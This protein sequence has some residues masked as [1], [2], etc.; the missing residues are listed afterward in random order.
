MA[1]TDLVYKV[2]ALTVFIIIATQL[3]IPVVDDVQTSIYSEAMNTTSYFAVANASDTVTITYD[4]DTQ[5]IVVN[6]FTIPD[7]PNLSQYKLLAYAD[8]FFLC[9]RLS[10]SKIYLES[11]QY[12]SSISITSGTITI[13]ADK[14]TY[15]ETE[16]PY[17]GTLYYAAESGDLGLFGIKDPDL[18]F[19]A[20]SELVTFCATSVAFIAKGTYDNMTMDFFFSL[21]EDYQG[22]ENPGFI[23]GVVDSNQGYYHLANNSRF[24]FKIVNSDDSVTDTAVGSVSVVAPIE[25]R[26]TGPSDVSMINLIGVIPI[27]VIIAAIVMAVGL[28][29]GKS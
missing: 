23:S 29:R 4:E 3:L 13:D 17:S 6:G 5:E 16:I 28:L 7:T 26:Y 21:S 10:V 11:K 18:K 9:Y 2:V 27:L 24:E 1:V 14:I 15:S 8:D 25:Y 20:D 22:V 12:G 19:N